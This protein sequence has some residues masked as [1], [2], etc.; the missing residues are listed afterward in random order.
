MAKKKTIAVE[1]YLHGKKLGVCQLYTGKL[2]L[3]FTL[4][5]AMQACISCV[6]FMRDDDL[7]HDHTWDEF[8]LKGV[9][10]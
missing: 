3:P 10:I 2:L 6:C 4:Q 5:Q 7:L 1:V 9:V 8:E